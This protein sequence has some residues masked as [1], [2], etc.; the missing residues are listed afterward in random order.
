M[1]I[2]AKIK[3][4]TIYNLLKIKIKVINFFKKIV[5]FDKKNKI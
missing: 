1:I 5:E 2:Y 3:F 4:F